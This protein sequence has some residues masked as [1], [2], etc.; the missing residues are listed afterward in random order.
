MKYNTIFKKIKDLKVGAKLNIYSNDEFIIYAIRPSTL[1]KDMQRKN[2]DVRTNFQVWLN[3]K[4]TGYEFM[5]THLRVLIGLK[6]IIMNQ[7][8][9][10]EDLLLAFDK[11]FYGEDPK[12]AIKNIKVKVKYVDDLD[13]TAVLAQLLLIEQ[14]MGFAGE[15]KYDPKSLWL[16]GWIRTFIDSNDEIEKLIKSVFG[17]GG[18]SGT[19]K[20]KYTCQDNKKTPKKYNQ[21]AKPLWYLQ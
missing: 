10:R 11:I 13:I 12:T 3:N 8:E 1:N 4:R 7:P 5:P 21:N 19:P 6:I 14:E 16:Q 9:L 15:S 18:K 17:Y 20:V 2:Y